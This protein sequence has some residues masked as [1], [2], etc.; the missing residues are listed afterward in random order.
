[1]QLELTLVQD[2]EMK[3]S[4][5]AA[6]NLCSF[7]EQKQHKS[8]LFRS[9][10][11]GQQLSSILTKLIPQLSDQAS[12]HSVELLRRIF[13]P[14]DAQC[15]GIS[16]DLAVKL[17]RDSPSSEGE[18]TRKYMD[19]ANAASERRDF[20]RANQALTAAQDAAQTS[21]HQ[22]KTFPSGRTALQHL[23]DLHNAYI[24][25]HRN[26]TGMAY[27]ESVGVAGYLTTLLVHYKDNYEILRIFEDFQGRYVDFQIPVCQERMFDLAAT[28]AQKL[29]LKEKLQRYSDQHFQWLKK[30]PFSDQWGR[31]TESALS[32][33][34]QYLRQIF[35]G[36]EDP[37]GWG[38]NAME[39][40]LAWAKVEVKKG[41]LTKGS[42][43]ELFGFIQKDEQDNNTDSFLECFENLDFEEAAKRLYGDLDKPTPSATFLDIMQRLK[44]WLNLPD[45][46]P[47]QA[48][49]L[50]TAKIIMM[51]R[52]HRHRLHLASNGVPDPD[53]RREYSKEQ[54]LLDAI[55]KLEDAVGGGFGDQADRQITSRIHTTLIKCDVPESA[56]KRLVS[57]EELPSWILDSVDLVSEYANVGRRRVEAE[58]SLL[59]Q[60]ARMRFQVTLKTLDKSSAEVKA[61]LETA[62]VQS[63]YQRFL[64]WA[65]NLGLFQKNHSS[66]DYRLRENE[67]I[68]SFTISLL[69]SLIRALKESQ[70]QCAQA[71]QILMKYQLQLSQMQRI[72]ST[73]HLKLQ[74]HISMMLDMLKAPPTPLMITSRL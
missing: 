44:D 73:I 31:L 25:L 11:L 23:Q 55:E 72:T 5:G 39:L 42:L 2:P 54:Q 59:G 29:A 17:V 40:I 67:V 18:K 57:D 22:C 16:F 35:H 71:S 28:A 62:A 38:S 68:R 10:R 30:C 49:R 46:P 51:S 58:L 6:F 33:P 27:F 70:Y 1:M 66:L 37:V 3:D 24:G 26:E 69:T 4:V 74:S 61:Q 50:D 21:W 32:D 7:M 53:N 41:L 47:S 13:S 45:R 64:L 20:T 36:A 48:A 14:M 9:A 12:Q 15:P 56:N 65:T 63:E 19:L 52:L 34:N 60:D 8:L 43:R